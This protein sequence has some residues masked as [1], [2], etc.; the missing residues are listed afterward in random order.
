MSSLWPNVLGAPNLSWP[1][2]LNRSQHATESK[3]I[4]YELEISFSGILWLLTADQ[5]R[6]CMAVWRT[7]HY[8]RLHAISYFACSYW[9]KSNKYKKPKYIWK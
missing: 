5:A 1:P 2:Q 6:A 4:D 7:I 3:G 8:C 9:T